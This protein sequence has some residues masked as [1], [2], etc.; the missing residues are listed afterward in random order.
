MWMHHLELVGWQYD[1]CCC[2]AFSSSNDGLLHW[3]YYL[4]TNLSGL[5]R[6]ICHYPHCR[7]HR[8][9]LAALQRC[10]LLGPAMM[11]S[12]LPLWQLWAW[13]WGG[14]VICAPSNLLF[15]MIW[16]SSRRRNTLCRRGFFV[17]AMIPCRIFGIGRER[18]RM[19]WLVVLCRAYRVQ[20][21]T[22]HHIVCVVL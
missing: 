4:P 12:R 7:F 11:V 13:W 1:G 21:V 19:P 22:V 16:S 3:P 10:R 20:V 9:L 8:V 5:H 17:W 14:I 18:L 15:G 2:L 6:P